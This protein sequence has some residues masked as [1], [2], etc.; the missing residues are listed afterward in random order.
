MATCSN[1]ETVNEEF[2]GDA[3]KN[4]IAGNVLFYGATQGFGYI[5]GICGER[6]GVRN[7]GASLVTISV[8]SHGLEYMTGGKV[9]I[10]DKIGKNFASGMSGGVAFIRNTIENIN[11]NL[12]I[13]DYIKLVPNDYYRV[14]ELIKK[15]QNE[16]NYLIKVFNEAIK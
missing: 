16:E 6:F 9:L 15:Y 7:S 2:N 12:N 14:C 8:G 5:N 13:N 1:I 3:S 4:I 11:N 10:L